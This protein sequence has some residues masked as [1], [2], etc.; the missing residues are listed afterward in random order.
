M[1]Q[2]VE[3]SDSELNVT[4]INML[5]STMEKAGNMKNVWTI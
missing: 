1:T 5:G 3:L 4:V 2:F